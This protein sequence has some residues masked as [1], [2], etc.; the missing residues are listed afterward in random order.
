STRRGRQ[1]DAMRKAWTS[2]RR[3]MLRRTAGNCCP[4]QA[5]T[6]SPRVSRG[7]NPA[8]EQPTRIH[9]WSAPAH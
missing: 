3:D 4:G 2:L 5:V 1:L 9:L 8:R 7:P 6:A